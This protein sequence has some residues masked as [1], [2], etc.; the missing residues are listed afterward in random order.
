MSRVDL[1]AHYREADYCVTADS[2]TLIFRISRHD[3]ASERRLRDAMGRYDR[4]TVV[5]PCNPGSVALCEH[6]NAARLE[7]FHHELD[8][9]VRRWLRSLSRDP[10][11]VWP[12]EPGAMILDL[13][14]PEAEALGRRYGQNAIVYC[15]TGNAPELIWLA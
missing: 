10:A 8:A 6:E 4:W 12:D 5:T 9:D 15:A 11:G 2:R 1:E 14:L 13:P 7:N 3:P